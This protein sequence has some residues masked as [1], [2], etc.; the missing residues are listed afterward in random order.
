MP[1]SD[2]DRIIQRVQKLVNLAGNSG[3]FEGEANNAMK[4]A[5]ELMDKYNISEAEAAVHEAESQGQV[6]TV[7]EMEAHRRSP[8]IEA[9]F[10]DLAFVCQYLCDVRFF[11][12]DGWIPK[13]GMDKHFAELPEAEFG[14]RTGRPGFT[15]VQRLMFFGLTHDVTVA[16]ALYRE[17]A[18]SIRTLIRLRHGKLKGE[19]RDYA[20]GLVARLIERAM[21]VRKDS[22]AAA[23]TTAI[24][25]RKDVLLKAYA[26]DK[27][28]LVPSKDRIRIK[29]WQAYC[30]GQ[31]D[32]ENVSLD[33]RGLQAGKARKAFND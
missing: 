33:D 6:T 3:A 11:W 14:K 10:R 20:A 12:R 25:L 5:R 2:K 26:T 21:A 7:E 9:F 15:K 32:G 29:N 30:Q 18:V 27:L 22:V 31:E 4:Y 1:I 23:G 28:N 24:V 13:R 19:A 17:L 8:N 16:V